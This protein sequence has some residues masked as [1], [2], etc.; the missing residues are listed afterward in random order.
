MKTTTAQHT[1]NINNINNELNTLGQNLTTLFNSHI[2]YKVYT[3]KRDQGT[4]GTVSANTWYF[5]QTISQ[6]IETVP[7]GVTLIP[8]HI[9]YHYFDTTESYNDSSNKGKTLTRA[10]TTIDPRSKI[11]A[12][13]TMYSVFTQSTEQWKEVGYYYTIGVLEIKSI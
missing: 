6:F 10:I 3:S 4:G 9:Q 13:N 7:S 11:G 12:S 1:N 5:S 2:Q 8:I